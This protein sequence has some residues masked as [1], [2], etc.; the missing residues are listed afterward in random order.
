MDEL[1]PILLWVFAVVLA[2]C[3]VALACRPDP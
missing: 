1:V 3:A 2:G